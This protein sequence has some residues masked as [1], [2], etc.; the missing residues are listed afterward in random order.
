M[1][2]R[3]KWSGT[4]AIWATALP[5]ARITR[6]FIPAMTYVD[7]IGIDTYGLCSGVAD[8]GPLLTFTDNN[9]FGLDDAIKMSASRKASR[10]ASLRSAA[11]Q[12]KPRSRT[13]F[14]PG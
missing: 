5:A 10:F 13:T 6:S 8:N 14:G 3:L 11:G 9:H 2:S 1:A 7:H 4:P 12:A